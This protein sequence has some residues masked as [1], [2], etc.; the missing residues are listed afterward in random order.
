MKRKSLLIIATLIMIIA[1]CSPSVPEIIEDSA[2]ETPEEL[3]Q[4]TEPLPDQRCK[5][6]IYPLAKDNQWV[7]EMTYSGQREE[8]PPSK[9]AISVAGTS[10][11][12]AEVGILDYDTGIVTKSAV[13]CR[14]GA[15]INFPFTELNMLI[16]EVEGSLNLEYVSGIFMPSKTDFDQQ[17]WENS[18]ET[19]YSASGVIQAEME[20]E[21][22]SAELDAS[23]VTMDWQVAGTGVSVE[24]K[25]GSFNDAVKIERTVSIEIESMQAEIEGTSMEFSTTLKIDS[26]LYFSPNIGLVKQEIEN[27][28][29]RFFGVDFPVGVGGSVELLSYNLAE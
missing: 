22:M 10:D 17:N 13:K 6:I 2:V 23:S 18:W 1:A 27:A 12:T 16:A 3:A 15:I 11:S 4:T 5:N 21:Q 29:A 7:Y 28:T 25:A 20:G 9:F 26:V 14:E 24:T 19:E 8:I